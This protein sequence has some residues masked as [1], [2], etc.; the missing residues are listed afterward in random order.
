M[1]CPCP[2]RS[3]WNRA[4]E[5]AKARELALRYRLQFVDV[6]SF[7]PDPVAWLSTALRKNAASIGARTLLADQL[8]K[9]GNLEG[10]VQTLLAAT[11]ISPSYDVPY[12]TAAR[13]LRDAGHDAEAKELA[14]IALALRRPLIELYAG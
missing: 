14:Q 7:A 4:D 3:R 1:Y 6:A 8:A 2:V 11:E 13:I 12:L 10:A 9:L 5:T